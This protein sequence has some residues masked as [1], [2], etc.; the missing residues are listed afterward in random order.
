M[1]QANTKNAPDES[2]SLTTTDLVEEEKTPFNADNAEMRSP[3]SLFQPKSSTEEIVVKF[4]R[5]IAD[6]EIDEAENILKEHPTLLPDILHKQ[7]TVTDSTGC[8]YKDVSALHLIF[9][10]FNKPAWD[11]IREGKYLPAADLLKQ[12]EKFQ[13]V[14]I[15]YKLKTAAHDQFGQHVDLRALFYSMNTYVDKYQEWRLDQRHGYWNDKVASQFALL[16]PYFRQQY[17]LHNGLKANDENELHTIHLSDDFKAKISTAPSQDQ[18]LCDRRAL[19]NIYEQGL[20]DFENLKTEL[21]R[22]V[23][24]KFSNTW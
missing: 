10:T 17:R 13:G 18:V 16:P 7:A 5:H 1:G 15:Y 12:A 2:L 8:T 3:Y 4:I 14:Y 20:T 11:M 21:R 9:R 6:Q 22:D 24:L 23:A 19:E